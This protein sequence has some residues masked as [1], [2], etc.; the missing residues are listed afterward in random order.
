MPVSITFNTDGAWG[1]GI[2]V[3]PAADVDENF[4]SIKLAIDALEADRP[5]PN[6]IASITTTASG[7]QWIVHLDDGTQLGPLPI[8]V[9]QY[10]D[11]GAWQAFT[12][13]AVLDAFTDPTTGLYST[14]IAHTSAATFDPEAASSPVA[15]TAIEAG[16][17]YKIATLGTTDFTLIGATGNTVGLVFTATA[18][19]TGSGTASPFL[20]HLILATVTDGAVSIEVTDDYTLA[21]ADGTGYKRI[22]DPSAA[23]VTIP[24]N[25]DVAFAVNVSVTIEQADSGPVTIQGGSGVTLRC[26]DTHTPVTNGQYAVAQVKQIA[27]DEW[28]IFGNLVPA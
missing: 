27:A 4:Y 17:D 24:P 11:R 8:P 12:A 23:T 5:Q 13:Y 21:L 1:S 3:L 20:Y 15:A 10:R 14:R 25:S 16:A 18:A 28:I 6:N 26:P 19:G 2:G 9:L 22:S 7:T